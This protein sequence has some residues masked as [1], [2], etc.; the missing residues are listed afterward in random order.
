MAAVDQASVP[1]FSGCVVEGVYTAENERLGP[2]PPGELHADRDA[3]SS[4]PA[5]TVQAGRPRDPAASRSPSR[6][7]ETRA[8]A[9]DGHGAPRRSEAAS[10]P[11]PGSGARRT[12]PEEP[13]EAR[14][15]ALPVDRRGEVAPRPSPSVARS[16]RPRTSAPYSSLPGREETG[17]VW[18]SSASARWITPKAEYASAPS[19]SSHLDDLGT[20]HRQRPRTAAS[21]HRGRSLPAPRG[22]GPDRHRAEGPESSRSSRRRVAERHVLGGRIVRSTP[23]IASSRS[24]A[25]AGVRAIGPGWSSERASGKTP[26]G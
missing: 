19:G 5:R 24:A 6:A 17:L 11:R 26:A 4:K 2:G 7:R 20:A 10:L 25:S 12:P 1:Y 15:N 3:G 9:R 18:V 22:R 21:T 13:R 16:S 14:T 23:A 8:L